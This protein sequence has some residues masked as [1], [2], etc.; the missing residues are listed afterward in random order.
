MISHQFT[1]VNGDSTAA[2][3]CAAEFR[4]LCVAAEK[5]P[6]AAGHVRGVGVSTTDNDDEEEYG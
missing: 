5:D 2:R 4:Y 3:T 1:I 6:G